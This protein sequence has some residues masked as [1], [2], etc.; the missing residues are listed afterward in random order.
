[1]YAFQKCVCFESDRLQK[2]M[3]LRWVII[4]AEAKINNAFLPS[5]L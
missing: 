3:N 4:K 2:V 5:L 1:M